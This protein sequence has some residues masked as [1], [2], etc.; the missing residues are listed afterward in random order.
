MSL[1]KEQQ[2]AIKEHLRRMFCSAQFELDG[3]VINVVR[4]R[5]SERVIN[6]TVYI[7]GSVKGINL[8]GIDERTEEIAKRVY[9]HRSKAH[10]SPKM[11]KDI[12]K[13]WGKREAKK[14]F[15]DLHEKAT[16]LDCSFNTSASLVRQFTKLEGIKL[17]KLGGELV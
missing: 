2:Q 17:V 14:R 7:D 8:G 11:I 3:H 13:I 6:L 9:R 10:Y 5:K 15:P 4:E 1:T 12:E 16:Y